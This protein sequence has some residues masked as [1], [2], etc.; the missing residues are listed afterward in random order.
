M[1]DGVDMFLVFQLVV[2]HFRTLKKKIEFFKLILSIS[3]QKLF[4]YSRPEHPS[5]IEYHFML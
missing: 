3:V 1:Q 4:N 2:A 5:S